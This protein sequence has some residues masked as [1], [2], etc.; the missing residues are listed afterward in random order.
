MQTP[1]PANLPTL[2]PI[3]AYSH[4]TQMRRAH[5]T[6]PAQRELEAT[7]WRDCNAGF[8][9][10]AAR[11]ST[12]GLPPRPEF[13]AHP[14]TSATSCGDRAHIWH[15]ECRLPI[16][17]HSH[18]YCFPIDVPNA[19]VT[20]GTREDKLRVSGQSDGPRHNVHRHYSQ[21]D[22]VLTPILRATV[23]CFPILQLVPRKNPQFIIVV[24]LALTH[25]RHL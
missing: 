18:G 4:D 10:P 22:H 21:R 15:T 23:N 25:P 19:T 6:A 11:G 24:D 17:P 2:N 20:Y 12:R 9:S 5:P 1:A 8:Q 14:K 7:S 13:L 16:P 3:Y